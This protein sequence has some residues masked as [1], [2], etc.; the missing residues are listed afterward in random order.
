MSEPTSKPLGLG[1]LVLASCP[2]HVH[3][4]PIAA[5]QDEAEELIEGHVLSEHCR[6]CLAALEPADRV[7]SFPEACLCCT[8]ELVDAEERADES[9]VAT[10][11]ASGGGW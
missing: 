2:D 4:R 8:A 5:H 6:Y 3:W 11:L 1:T 9:V 10:Q 7:G